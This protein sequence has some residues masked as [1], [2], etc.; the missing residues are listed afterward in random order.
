M[1]PI[2][3]LQ[4]LTYER[5][6]S[7]GSDS[8]SAL[9]ALSICLAILLAINSLAVVE[10]G[11]LQSQD[12][13]VDINIK[14]DSCI[15]NETT[16]M[17][18]SPYPSQIVLQYRVNRHWTKHAGMRR[19]ASEPV[20]QNKELSWTK[21]KEPRKLRD[22]LWYADREKANVENFFQEMNFV[23]PLKQYQH[24]FP[25]P[26]SL[27]S[28]LLPDAKQ[29][30]SIPPGWTS[31]MGSNTFQY[32]PEEKVQ[33]LSL[34]QTADLF[35]F[36]QNNRHCASNADFVSCK[37]FNAIDTAATA[38]VAGTPLL[39]TTNIAPSSQTGSIDALAFCG[40]MRLFADWRVLRQIPPSGYNT[41]AAGINLGY[42]DIILNVKKIENAARAW[43]ER[44]KAAHGTINHRPTLRDLL[45]E[46]IETN[47]HIKGLPKLED[48]SAA[49]GLLW[50]RRQ[51]EYQQR[52]YCNANDDQYKGN[53]RDVVRAA[54]DSVYSKYHGWAVRKVFQYSAATAPP[55]ELLIEYMTGKT[56]E[57]GKEEMVYFSTVV[58]PMLDD[59]LHLLHEMN[60]HDE[61]KV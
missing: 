29:F 7:A 14:C 60:M 45:T 18:P 19:A 1:E 12:A 43:I 54:Y 37:A 40:V 49:T 57:D 61:G 47:V 32:F 36:V 8:R 59:L 39:R 26:I 16:L 41:Y 3:T 20:I 51:L 24:Q 6:C 11:N 50:A 46:E 30:R 22:L 13:P 10:A 48:D 52:L 21:E 5:H 2:T 58:E 27:Q 15:S 34:K 17:P 25:N 4:F 9:V 33:S 53:I 23:A 35:T 28:G 38:V 44:R 31:I 55:L 42:K 56:V